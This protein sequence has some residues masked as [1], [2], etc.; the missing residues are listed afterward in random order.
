[1]SGDLAEA[2]ELPSEGG[3]L[4]Q[5]V[6][7]GSTA[8]EAGLRRPRQSV[9]VGNYRLGVGGDL[10]TA[11]DGKPVEGRDSLQRALS[12]K[13]AGETLDLTV[14]RGR[15]RTKIRVKLAEAPQSL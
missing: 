6:Q 11:I 15:S 8:E 9:I 4:I 2:L 5:E 1:V 12:R 13:R 7:P 3:L 10:I 14:Y